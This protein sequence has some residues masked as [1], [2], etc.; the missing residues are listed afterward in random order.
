MNFEQSLD[1]E[2][3]AALVAMPPL[4][5]L[6][7][8]NIVNARQATTEMLAAFQGPPSE[9]VTI[10]DRSIPGP[11][12]AP[13]VRIRFYAPRPQTE[14]L[15]GLLWIHGGGFLMGAP[16]MD[17]RLCQRFVEEVGCVIVSVDWRLAPENPFPAGVEDCYA[18]LVWMVKHASELLIDPDR[19]AVAGA[20]AG[21]GVTAAVALLARDRGGPRLA[22]QMPL[23]GCLDDRHI[24]LSS[25]EITDE[26]VWNRDISQ[27]AWK[28]YLAGSDENAISPYAAPARAENLADLPPAYICIGEADLMRDENIEYAMRL[29]QAGVSTELHIYPGAFHGFDIMVPTAQVSQRAVSEYVAALKRGLYR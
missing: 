12:G 21:G 16:A 22:F 5:N 24:T 11:A 20:S 28:L 1:P 8:D 14:V 19:I 3:R 27:R 2:L 4:G 18:A 10:E 26:R 9:N 6:L 7:I 29:M 15:P 23:Y 13:D 25:I 17:D